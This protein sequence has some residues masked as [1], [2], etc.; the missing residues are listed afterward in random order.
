M[1]FIKYIALFVKKTTLLMNNITFIINKITCLIIAIPTVYIVLILLVDDGDSYSG[2]HSP[3]EG[4]K[5][6]RAL[7]P[8]TIAW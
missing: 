5:Q 3:V 2:S 7:A 8:Y 1:I 4:S 6:T